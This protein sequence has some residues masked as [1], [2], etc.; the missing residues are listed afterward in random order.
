MMK[1][2]RNLL[3][4]SGVAALSLSSVI[5]VFAVGGTLSHSAYGEMHTYTL[6]ITAKDVSRGY[7]LTPSGNRIELYANDGCFVSGGEIHFADGGVLR[8][9]DAISG[10]T[11]IRAL[12]GASSSESATLNVETGF[13]SGVYCTSD[14]VIGTGSST[15]NVDGGERPYLRFTAEAGE[16]DLTVSEIDIAYT[17]VDPF[18]FRPIMGTRVQKIERNREYTY[19]G[20]Q[21]LGAAKPD[22]VEV[23]WENNTI[24]VDADGESIYTLHPT[25]KFYD[26]DG[27]LIKQ[28]TGLW[29]VHVD[30]LL[31]FFTSTD[32][33]VSFNV[34]YGESF[35]MDNLYTGILSGYDW[36]DYAEIL[37]KPIVSSADFYPRVTVNVNPGVHTTDVPETTSFIPNPSAVVNFGFPEIDAPKNVT[38]NYNF[39]AWYDGDERYDHRTAKDFHDYDLCAEYSSEFDLRLQFRNRGFDNAYFEVGLADGHGFTMPGDTGEGAYVDQSTLGCLLGWRFAKDGTGNYTREEGYW[40]YPEG[41]P[42]KREFYPVGSTFVNDG[43]GTLSRSVTYVAE[44]LSHYSP[45]KS[46]YE[47]FTLDDGVDYDANLRGRTIQAYHEHLGN[48]DRD[49]PRSFYKKLIIPDSCNVTGSLGKGVI[50]RAVNA[51]SAEE[52]KGIVGSDQLEV[53][54]GNDYFEDTGKRGFINNTALRRLEYFPALKVI[55]SYAFEGCVELEPIQDWRGVDG[56]TL[57]ETH[58]FDDCFASPR[59]N[60][61]GTIARRRFVLPKTLERMGG[62]AFGGAVYTDFRIEGCDNLEWIKEKAFAYRPGSYGNYL[63]N[64]HSPDFAEALDRYE[65][66]GRPESMIPLLKGVANHVYFDGTVA[67]WNAL[68]N[69]GKAHDGQAQDYSY[70]ELANLLCFEYY[71][72]FGGEE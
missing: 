13:S 33:F 53:V 72:T 12:P 59:L 15:R 21:Y 71:V 65:E 44:A 28:A 14:E 67:E 31:R 11:E 55:N 2:N 23:R 41:E 30:S 52:A 51:S 70:D 56:V 49:E 17:C 38:E 22:D 66:A 39:V 61:D 32:E 63:A 9:V 42:E 37:G 60:P 43:K 1:A 62:V 10:T 29:V 57:I 7:A 47:Y 69:A 18:A 20:L 5:T 25:A 54:V 64:E 46:G 8:P 27:Y 34:G 19:D 48:E 3:T 40:V 4:L 36:S 45:T 68:V 16:T 50:F 6:E 58:A 35:D 24:N 26:K